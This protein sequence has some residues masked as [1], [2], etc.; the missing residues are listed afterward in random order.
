MSCKKADLKNDYS[1][2][3]GDYEWVYAKISDTEYLSSDDTEENY[4]F[5]ITKS[6]K[7]IN[8]VNGVE[9]D[10]YMVSAINNAADGELIISIKVGFRLYSIA[11]MSE[12]KEVIRTHEFPLEMSGTSYFK[13]K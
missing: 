13:K 12:D 10:R 9:Q 7:L 2:V 5:R 4:G 1:Y 8:F 11:Y 6:G 3:Q